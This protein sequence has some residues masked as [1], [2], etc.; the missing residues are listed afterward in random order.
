MIDEDGVRAAADLCDRAGAR[1]FEIGYL[2]DEGTEAFLERGAEWYAQAL[3]KGTRVI[4][5]GHALPDGAADALARR[6]LTGARCRCGALVAMSDEGA[7]A[8]PGAQMADGS[9]W[10]EADIHEAGQCR[11]TRRGSRWEPGCDVASIR[12]K[13]ER[14]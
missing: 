14:W 1:S 4:A 7:V 9:V 10:S 11:W 5:E 12:V 13:G 3:Y 8:F 6:M 2:N